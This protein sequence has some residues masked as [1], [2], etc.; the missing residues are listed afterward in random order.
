MKDEGKLP[1][2]KN[3]LFPL[4]RLW[5]VITVTN[6]TSYYISIKRKLNMETEDNSVLGE[7]VSESVLARCWLWLG[8]RGMNG[9]LQTKQGEE[10][11]WTSLLLWNMRFKWEARRSLASEG[12]KSILSQPGKERFQHCFSINNSLPRDD[13]RF[14]L[15]P[16]V[17][18]FNFFPPKLHFISPE[19]TGL[20]ESTH[21]KASHRT[22]P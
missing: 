8:L 20:W 9:A 4:Q 10:P 16:N 19:K 7:N 14:K 2:L 22:K 15:N 18:T 6:P 17:T 5:V 1:S 3:M 11:G 12:T 21:L 13:K